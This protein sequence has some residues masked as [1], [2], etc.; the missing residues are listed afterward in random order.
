MS[1]LA[2]KGAAWAH[3]IP[4]EGMHC[5]SDGDAEQPGWTG[6]MPYRPRHREAEL[7][8]THGCRRVL[9]APA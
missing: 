6:I 5:G 4:E 8:S 2:G 3:Q 1:G 7:L 9:A